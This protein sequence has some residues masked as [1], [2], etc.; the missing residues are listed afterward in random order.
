MKNIT[1]AGRVGKDATLRST[2]KDNVLS[3]P[4]ATDDGYGKDK[5]TMWFD[6]SVWGKR[7]ETLE[8]MLSKGTAVTVAGELGT[9]VHEANTYLT[10]NVANVTLQGGGERRGNDESRQER[11]P[12]AASNR[13]NGDY[14]EDSGDV[15]PF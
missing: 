8:S 15:I 12:V 9:R 5:K 10:V 3:F 4:V 2:G 1:I 11:R 14:L 13:D 7:G 6:C